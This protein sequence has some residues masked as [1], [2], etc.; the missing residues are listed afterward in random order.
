MCA[1]HARICVRKIVKTINHGNPITLCSPQ[2]RSSTSRWPDIYVVVIFTEDCKGIRIVISNQET[3]SSDYVLVVVSL[4]P[5]VCSLSQIISPY[6]IRPL[7]EFMAFI[8]NAINAQPGQIYRRFTYT[9]TSSPG[10]R[11]FG[12][13]CTHTHGFRFRSLDRPTI[14]SFLSLLYP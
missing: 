8:S 6:Q 4:L 11:Q 1:V 10:E 14:R 3:T 13:K 2:A 9:S 7:N 5:L 12:F